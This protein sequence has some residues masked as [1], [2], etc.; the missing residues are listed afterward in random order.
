MNCMF[1]RWKPK[2]K[3]IN[4]LKVKDGEKN[5]HTNTKQHKVI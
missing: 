2:H 4:K 5:C 3:D 1:T